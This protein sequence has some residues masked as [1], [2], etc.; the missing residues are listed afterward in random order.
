MVPSAATVG[1]ALEL[2][3][4][5][6]SVV[7]SVVP[8]FWSASART[9]LRKDPTTTR[10]EV[11][12]KHRFARL[13][14]GGLCI[15]VLAGPLAAASATASTVSDKKVEAARLQHE[16]EVNGE[17]ISMLAER[18]D[19]AKLNLDSATRRIGEVE[20]R[21]LSAQANTDRIRRMVGRR[22]AAIYVNAGIQTPLDSINVT[23]VS[24]VGRRDTYAGATAER[25]SAMLDQLAASRED[26]Q[27]ARGQL[28]SARKTA[29]AH[30]DEIESSRREVEAANASQA[31]LLSQVKG[32]IATLI[33]QEQARQAAAEKARSDARASQLRLLATRSSSS[34]TT[35]GG[36]IA[37]VGTPGT[38]PANLPVPNAPAP[39]PGAA[40]AVAYAKAQLG[41][42]YRYAGVGPDAYDCS[43]LTMMAWAQA[44]VSMPHG[45]IAQGNMFPR[46][47]DNALQPGDLVIFYPDHHHVGMYV[48][49]GMTVSATQ[50]GD[51]IRLQP[52]F[53]SSYQF[54][55]R[56]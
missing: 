19:A 15:A 46:V 44:G 33:A 2:V 8:T 24:D 21:T 30:I 3:A 52:V 11:P 7:G 22:A 13:A 10:Q 45:S 51:F 36:V 35:S 16:I 40:T 48:G 54:A 18:Y 23:S 56:P 38:D 55:V 32:E 39:S 53:R 49:D 47:P 50:T 17:K 14:L 12:M 41:K 42:P 25:D 9:A 1:I 4:V 43:G 29:Q 27:V 34:R 6:Q 5:L 20:A 31:R 37:P 26:L 28:E